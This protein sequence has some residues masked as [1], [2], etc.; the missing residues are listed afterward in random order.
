MHIGNKLSELLTEKRISKIELANNIGKSK[1]AVTSIIKRPNI[2][3]GLL[4]KISQFLKVPISTFFEEK[5]SHAEEQ[6]YKQMIEYISHHCDISFS[7]LIQYKTTQIGRKILSDKKI[8][9]DS[10][11][12]AISKSVLSDVNVQ[13][14]IKHKVIPFNKIQ[15]QILVL[16]WEND[17]LEI[18]VG[19]DKEQ[20][21]LISRTADRL[22]DRMHKK[23]SPGFTL[24]EKVL[25]ET[26][27]LTKSEEKTKKKK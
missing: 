7:E 1:Q 19:F 9:A 16:L 2:D 12:N 18:M 27:R 15:E 25:K 3:T 8:D 20:S 5:K 4:E 6:E 17:Y 22:F 21:K 10:Y 24:D 11:I 23:N 13:L 14:F 26:D